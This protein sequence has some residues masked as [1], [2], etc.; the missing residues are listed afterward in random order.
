MIVAAINA[1]TLSILSGVWPHY[2][3]ALSKHAE[4]LMLPFALP[5]ILQIAQSLQKLW[6]P[7]LGCLCVVLNGNIFTSS[8]IDSP[9]LGI[10]GF[11]ATL[12]KLEVVTERRL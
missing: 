9:T 10:R 3:S 11:H 5:L 7:L 1:I 6:P 2:P 12:A 4:A 8:V